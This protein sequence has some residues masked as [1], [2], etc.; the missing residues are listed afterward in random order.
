MK[1]P[2]ADTFTQLK[3]ALVRKGLVNMTQKRYFAMICKLLTEAAKKQFIHTAP[4]LAP[5]R[6]DDDPR[7][8]FN[9]G[10]YT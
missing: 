7:S 3:M 9:N 1:D 5:M 8:Y 10:K 6:I 4:I 2:N